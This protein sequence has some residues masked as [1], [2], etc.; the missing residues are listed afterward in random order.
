MDVALGYATN[1]G[2]L[3][4]QVADYKEGD[5]KTEAAKAQETVSTYNTK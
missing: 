3:R 1:P 5:I 4:L 2:N